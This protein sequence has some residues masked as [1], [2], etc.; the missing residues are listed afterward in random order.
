MWLI[1]TARICMQDTA[2]V[3]VLLNEGVMRLDQYKANQ[4][5]LSQFGH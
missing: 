5:T 2:V 3:C 4:G 1:I